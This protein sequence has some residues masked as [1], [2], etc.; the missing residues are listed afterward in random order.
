MVLF[1]KISIFL[2]KTST[3]PVFNFV[4]IVSSDLFLTVPN[5]LTVDSIGIWDAKSTSCDS[6]D[7]TACVIPYISLMS[8]N[9]TPPKSLIVSTNPAIRTFCP[10]SFVVI[11]SQ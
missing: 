5:M 4:F 2:I 6:A 1:P 3:N 9:T 11:S 7:V 10:T 8:R